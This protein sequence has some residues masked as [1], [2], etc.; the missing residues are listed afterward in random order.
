M[1]SGAPFAWYALEPVD[2]PATLYGATHL[3]RIRPV[4]DRQDEP[5]WFEQYR[6]V[7]AAIHAN[8]VS[9]N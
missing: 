6:L 4:L 3:L 2:E 5:G 7:R 8:L 1:N 9:R